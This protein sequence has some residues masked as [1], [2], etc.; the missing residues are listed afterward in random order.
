M[1]VHGQ[2]NTGRRGGSAGELYITAKVSGHRLFEREG[3]DLSLEV[4]I[5]VHEAALGATIKVPTIDGSANLRIP[6]GTQS[7]QRFRLRSLGAPAPRTG[8]RGDLLVEVRVVLPPLKDE[9]SRELMRELGHINAADVRR[10]L[11]VE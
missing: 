8:E 2:G 1:R 4:P 6:A 9:R 3:N 7:G 5:G 11:F 10:D